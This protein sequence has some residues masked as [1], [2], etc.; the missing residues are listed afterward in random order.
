MRRGTARQALLLL[1]PSAQPAR[2]VDGAVCGY[3]LLISFD[4]TKITSVLAGTAPTAYEMELEVE[5]GNSPY[6][7]TTQ[8]TL[9]VGITLN[10]VGILEGA[11]RETGTFPLTITATD[12]FGIEVELTAA[13][14]VITATA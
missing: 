9:P 6:V 2:R 1:L 11:P 4:S 8:S 14:L 7:F 3:I 13:N 10:P 5:G 12:Y